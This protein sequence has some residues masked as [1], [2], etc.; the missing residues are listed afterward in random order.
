[1]SQRNLKSDYLANDPNL[2]PF[3]A[4]PY[5]MADYQPLV[6]SREQ[7]KVDRGTLVDVLRQQNEGQEGEAESLAQIDLLL[8]ENTYTVTTGHQ[9]VLMGGPMYMLYKIAT[10][11]QLARIMQEKHPAIK[12]VPVFWMASEDHDW[13]EIN[14]FGTG[15]DSKITYQ[16]SFEGPVGRHILEEVVQENLAELPSQWRELYKPGTTLSQAFRKLIARLFKGHGLIILD[17]DDARLKQLFLPWME[18]ELSGTGMGSHIESSSKALEA[19]GYGAQVHPRN[20]NLFYMGEGKRQLIF[21]DGDHFVSKDGASRWS[22]AELL[23]LLAAQPEEFSPNATMRPLYQEVILPNLAYI[24]GWAEIS[25]WHQ[26]KAA[27]EAAEVPFPL[28]VPR[29]SATLIRKEESEALEGLGLSPTALDLPSHELSAAYLDQIWSSEGLDQRLQELNNAYD[30]LAAY[31]DEID[32][33]LSRGVLAEQARSQ[34][35]QD[36]LGKK[37]KRAIK[38]RNP[39]PFG[40][41]DE[42]KNKIQPDN[43]R[44]E[45]VL[46]FTLFAPEDHGSLVK[47]ILSE[48]SP[49]SY[50]TPWIQLP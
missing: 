29:M 43:S 30:N 26:L 37:L 16:G 12:V 36:K 9:L 24:G 33:T 41:L 22:K 47:L 17:A 44:Q 2:A 21:A 48:C 38:N 5:P 4:F 28:L 39:K 3:N 31:V 11:I 10:V 46:N 42:L 8:N 35:A 18:R 40:L 34:K 13:E 6:K 27:F 32:P 50:S 14:H 7:L 49:E 45:R 15:F 1:M 19:A 23:S 20:I 25:Y